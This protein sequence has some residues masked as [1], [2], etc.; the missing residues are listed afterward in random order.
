MYKII[1]YFCSDLICRFTEMSHSG[2]MQL[3][4]QNSAQND[5]SS[6]FRKTAQRAPLFKKLR[7]RDP[8][9]LSTLADGWSL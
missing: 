1:K 5:D 4:L 6:I 2:A 8:H 9:F 3:F 7:K